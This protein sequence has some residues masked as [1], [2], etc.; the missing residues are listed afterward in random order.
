MGNAILNELTP[1]QEQAVLDILAKLNM[2]DYILEVAENMV[3]PVP[4]DTLELLGTF[5]VTG[6]M[7]GKIEGRGEY[8][9]ALNKKLRGFTNGKAEG[10]SDRQSDNR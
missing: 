7:R 4:K 6:Y 1:Q 10:F 5:Y 2:Q 9:E 3:Y 8:A